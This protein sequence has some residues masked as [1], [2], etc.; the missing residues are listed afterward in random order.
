[1][2]MQRQSDGTYEQIGF[3]KSKNGENI[4]TI[5]DAKGNVYFT[6]GFTREISG[7]PPL[8]LDAIGKNTLDYKI[9]GNSIQNGTPSP[10]NPVEVQSVGDLITEGE[11]TGKYEIP[12]VTSGQNQKSVTT[13]IYL[14]KPLR[15]IGDYSDIL[16]YKEQYVIINCNK[17]ILTDKNEW[18]LSSTSRPTWKRY[19]IGVGIIDMK[20][21]APISSVAVSNIYVN[22]TSESA[23]GEMTCR[24]G[25][26]SRQ[27]WAFVP[28]E[29]LGNID[30]NDTEGIL[31]AWKNWLA[32][33]NITLW[34]PLASP[35][36]EQIQIPTIPTLKGTTIITTDTK[37]QPSDMEITYKVR[38]S[39]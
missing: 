32:E 5:L 12:V 39:K 8:T 11:Y 16:N 18:F 25:N 2:I 3:I 38:K 26:G 28:F 14:D 34:Y 19:P 20:V 6:Q 27:F 36:T 23:K 35:E 21:N 4:D 17:K 29:M 31:V 15:K 9:Y 37:I 7:I 1:M 13:P 33:N 10:D 24:K 22:S 30:V